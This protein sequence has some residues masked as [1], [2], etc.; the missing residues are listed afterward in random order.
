MLYI[1]SYAESSFDYTIAWD[2]DADPVSS[3]AYNSTG[4]KAHTKGNQKNPANGISS[5]TAVD[6]ANDGGE[7]TIYITYRK[8]QSQH[9]NNDKGYVAI[10]D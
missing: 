6:Y 10:P 4:V 3:P 2:L 8:D 5:F 9:S 7:H 1:N